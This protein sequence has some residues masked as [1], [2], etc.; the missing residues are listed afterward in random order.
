MTSYDIFKT[1]L[2]GRWVAKMIIEF[3]GGAVVTGQG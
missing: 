2:R 1:T 3:A